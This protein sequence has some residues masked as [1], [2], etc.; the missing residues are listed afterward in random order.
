MNATNLL[1]NS[2]DAELMTA[3]TQTSEDQYLVELFI[4]YRLLVYGTCLKYLENKESAEDA[5]QDI[6]LS[7]GQKL[8]NHDVKEF[9]AWLYVV[10]K[11]FCLDKL[12]KNKRNFNKE[13]DASLM[14]SEQIFHPDDVNDEQVIAQLRTCMEILPN[15]QKLCIQKFYFEG[16]SYNEVEKDTGYDWNKIR[17]YIQNGRR[18]LKLCM[19]KK[20]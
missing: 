8:I 11:N 3:F 18:N 13:I 15:D 19:D 16:K 1:K 20:K 2:T 5:C 17:S 9:K 7:L 6:Y 12:R 10:T 4:R 14:Y